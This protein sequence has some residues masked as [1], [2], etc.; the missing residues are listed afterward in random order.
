MFTTLSEKTAESRSGLIYVEPS[1]LFEKQPESEFAG[2]TIVLRN[3]NLTRE[4]RKYALQMA[5]NLPGPR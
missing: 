2:A 5:I 4:N 1:N 3:S